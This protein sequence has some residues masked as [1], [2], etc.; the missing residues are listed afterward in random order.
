MEGF[1]ETDVRILEELRK[2][3]SEAVPSMARRLG[4]NASSAYGRIRRMRK[5]GLITGYTVRVDYRMLG[6][7]VRA[8]VGINRA[9]RFKDSIRSRLGGMEEVESVSE[10]TGRFDMVVG[11]RVRDLESLHSLVVDGLGRIEGV[12]NTETFIEL[13]PDSKTSSPTAPPRSRR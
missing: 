3:S 13:E 4:I 2:D 1:D 11:V 6:L 10:V 9:H 5:R 7:G 8:H 12:H